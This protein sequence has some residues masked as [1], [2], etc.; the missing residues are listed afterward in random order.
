MWTWVD[1]TYTMVFSVL[2][3]LGIESHAPVLQ[4]IFLSIIAAFYLFI[5]ILGY[6]CTVTDPTD[7]NVYYERELLAQK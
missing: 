5:I 2:C 3:I 1:L 7:P 6:V 4:A